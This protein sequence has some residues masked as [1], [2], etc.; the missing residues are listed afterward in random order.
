[1]SLNVVVHIGF[2]KTG[3]TTKQKHLFAKHSQVRFL[4]KP[5]GM[6]SLRKEI[7][8]LVMQESLTYDPT[9]LK[10]IFRD[11]LVDTPQTAPEKK[12]LLLSDEILV[13]ASKARDKGV[14]ANR[15]KEI[16]HPC[17]ILV[18]IRNQ[19][20]IVKSAY[21]NGGLYFRHVPEKYRHYVMSFQEWLDI[22]QSKYHG[23]FVENVKYIETIDFYATLFGSE[24]ICVLLFE[25]FLQDKKNY[26]KKL[27]AFL[28]IDETEAYNLLAE[29][30]ENKRLDKAELDSRK[31]RSK[32]GSIGTLPVFSHMAALL[33]KLKHS[34]GTTDKSSSQIPKEHHQKLIQTY[35]PGNRQLIEKYKLP[36][37]QYDYPL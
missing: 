16:F 7:A 17:K 11:A 9:P 33:G 32:F 29:A 19:M 5:Y 28:G 23:S 15:I 12:L 1:M 14:V 3:T 27:S 24:N 36:L 13:S 30:H 8:N 35:S 31:I 6:D 2:P 10:T 34:T 4:G 25:E 26:V 37:E 21:V 18:T 20:D 22:D